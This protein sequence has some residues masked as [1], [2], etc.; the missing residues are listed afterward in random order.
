MTSSP[1][2]PDVSGVMARIIERAARE[3]RTIV[4]PEAEDERVLR[5]AAE[6][7]TMG[8]AIPLLLGDPETIATAAARLGAAMLSA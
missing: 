5:A 7:S 1:G 3:P 4:L 8:F 6:I 2:A